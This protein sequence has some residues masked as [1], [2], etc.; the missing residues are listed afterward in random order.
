MKK[1]NVMKL[2]K[3]EKRQKIMN[4]AIKIFANAGY[5]NSRVSDIA[6]EAGIADG[7]IYLYFKSKDDVLAAIFNEA[8]TQFIEIANNELEGI[9]DPVER[10]EKIAWL[11]LKNLGSNKDLASVFQIEFRHN[12]MFME[13]LSKTRLDEYFGIIHQAIEEGQKQG[14][15]R[16]IHPRFAAKLFF[17]MIDEMVTNWLISP[18]KYKLEESAP[19]IVRLFVF[20]IVNS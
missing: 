18:R 16:K 20:G 14:K 17:G 2:K 19:Q 1:G 6:G 12:I 4:A 7:T 11:H 15:F 9:S 10:L 3:T 13:K 8:I 5:F